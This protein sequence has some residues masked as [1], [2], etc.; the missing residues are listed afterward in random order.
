MS[1]RFRVALSKEAGSVKYLPHKYGELSLDP[2]KS[3][4][5]LIVVVTFC[6]SA[7]EGRHGIPRATL[8]GSPGISASLG[9]E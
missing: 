3:R 7:S 5:S 2:Q 1:S 4:K 8:L 9:F 6:N